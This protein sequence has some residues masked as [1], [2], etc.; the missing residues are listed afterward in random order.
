MKQFGTDRKY[1]KLPVLV[2]LGLLGAV[3][4]I[5]PLFFGYHN[6]GEPVGV[7]LSLLVAAYGNFREQIHTYINRKRNT[8][9]FKVLVSVLAVIVVF[10]L[11]VAGWTTGKILFQKKPYQ[12]G[13]GTAVVLGC[14]V[15]RDGTPSAL[16]ESRLKTAL[17]YLQ[18]YPDEKAVVSGGGLDYY[19]LTEAESMKQWL[20]KH[21]IA[22]DR[23]Y[24]DDTAAS[25][26]Q[27]IVNAAEIVKQQ[28]LNPHLVLITN[29]FH[30]ARA[31]GIAASLGLDY[32]GL[33][34]KTPLWLAPTYYIR[35]MYGIVYTKLLE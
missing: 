30:Q 26:T 5:V 6:I 35:E 16:L 11:M 27:N 7:F 25:T 20:M 28:N 33:P 3:H 31:Q 9:G 21:G 17:A 1:R 14:E 15:N 22:E 13:P 24:T 34:A 29:T 8:T 18:K 32:T 19:G 4:F 2:I 12:E 23:I 10:H